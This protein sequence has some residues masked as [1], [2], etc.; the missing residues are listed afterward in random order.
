MNTSQDWIIF[1]CQ[2]IIYLKRQIGNCFYDENE[3]R[4]DSEKSLL[5]HNVSRNVIWLRHHYS[6]FCQDLAEETSQ[7]V[8]F[9]EN[10][11][12]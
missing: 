11:G 4:Q 12:Y 7:F 8:Y 5:P 1:N 6:K 10:C 3:C 2:K 9:S